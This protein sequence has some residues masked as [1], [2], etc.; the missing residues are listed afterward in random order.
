M[1][2]S[3]KELQKVIQSSVEKITDTTDMHLPGDDEDIVD[4]NDKPVGTQHLIINQKKDHF[5]RTI[6]LFV[7]VVAVLRL[8]VIDPFLVHGSSMEPTF[9]DGNYVIVDKLTYKFK[10]PLRGDVVI[11]DAPTE[12]GRYFIK[13][14]IGLPG[15]RISV[16]GSRVKIFN[17]KYPDGFT[18]E[19]PYVKFDSN[20]MSER[21]LEQDEYFVMG[22][23]RE[24]SSDSRIWGALTRQAITGRVLVRLLPFDNMGLFPGSLSKFPGAALPRADGPIKVT[25]P[26]EQNEPESKPLE[27]IKSI[28]SQ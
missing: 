24:V 3:D 21:V 16:D 1:S 23:N 8:F 17:E 20:R 11:F 26:V 18:L 5:W 28:D 15:D 7:F 25:E 14:V 4:L 22:D 12:D 19:E 13:R 10:D 6:L 27:S 2:L 9:E